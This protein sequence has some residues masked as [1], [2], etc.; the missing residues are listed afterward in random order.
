M[1][2]SFVFLIIIF[3][4]FLS[5]NIEL[6]LIELWLCV[7]VC[8]SVW[9]YVAISCSSNRRERLVYWFRLSFFCCCFVLFFLFCS[10]F[11]CT[12]AFENFHKTYGVN[13]KIYLTHKNIGKWDF[14]S[15]HHLMKS[16][17]FIFVWCYDVVFPDFF[18]NSPETINR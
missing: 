5:I 3:S 18:L 10:L 14:H 2:K 13:G 4:F 6:K 12:F 9:V 15:V 16:S 1:W 7:F 17:K 11:F 8:A